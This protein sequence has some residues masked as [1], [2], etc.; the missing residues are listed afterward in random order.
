MKLTLRLFLFLVLAGLL[1][2]SEGEVIP[3]VPPGF[4]CERPLDNGWRNLT[5]ICEFRDP[6]DA[7]W[8]EGEMPVVIGDD[9]LILQCSSGAQWSVVDLSIRADL[10]ALAVNSD[11]D[12]MVAGQYGALAFRKN[13][14]WQAMESLIET[15]WRDVRSQDRRMWLAGSGGALASCRPGNPLEMVSVPDD[16]DLY[17]V[18]AFQDSV[19]TGGDDGLFQVLANNQ[20]E[21]NSWPELGT[22]DVRSIVRLDDG[23]L[24]VWAGGLWIRE[25]DGWV[26]HHQYG[27]TLNS[28]LK[29]RGSFLWVVSGYHS[30]VRLDLSTDPWEEV[31]YNSPGNTICFAPG[32]E[33]RVLAV[34]DEGELIWFEGDADDSIIRQID[35]AGYLDT[36]HFFSLDDGMIVFAVDKGLF[37]ITTAGIEQVQTLNPEVEARLYESTL[38]D[39]A[40][41]DDFCSTA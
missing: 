23:R 12:L 35:P 13:G 34:S 7:V 3:L 21:D 27:Y 36:D 37:K 19:F 16:A 30:T 38:I 29:V 22:R 14:Q 41:L 9:G 31:D 6:A 11:G 32:P 17:A 39:G 15:D 5:N 40:S 8:P 26:R 10:A 1:G 33:S 28:H 18:C 2:C 20:W 24:A 25:L 4:V